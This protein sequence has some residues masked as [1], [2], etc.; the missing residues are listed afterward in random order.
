MAIAVQ[1]TPAAAGVRV[2]R[3]I[4]E[5]ETVREAWGAFAWPRVDADLDFLA[6][7]VEASPEAVRPHVAALDDAGAMLVGRIEETRLESHVGYRAVLKPRVRMLTV[8][9]GGLGGG[10]GAA[11]LLVD[12]VVSMLRA[13]EADVAVLPSLRTDSA[14]YEAARTRPPALSRDRVVDV[15]THRRLELPGSFDEF[16]RSRSK[17]TREGIKR[18]TKKFER[19]LGDRL[20]F[21]LYDEPHE[22]DALFAAVEPVA[23]K[24]Y[25]RGLGVA[26]HDDERNRRLVGLGL[27]RGWFRVWVLS[28]DG[29]PVAFWPG[30]VYNRSFYSSTPGYDPALAE[31]RLGQYVLMRLIRD[32]CDDPDADLLDFGFGDSEYKRRFSTEE[33]QEAD[34]LVFAP[35]FKGA[36]VNAGR[37]AVGLGERALRRAVER[38]GLEERIKRAW[39]RRLAA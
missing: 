2:A 34:V 29:E 24:T 5:L 13:G 31:Y 20:S 32:L 12:E 3:T 23:A 11:G 27:E 26:L 1:T 35:S 37:T 16:L 14:L 39:R 7:L 22:I 17:S 36:R 28:L 30:W 4:P 10:D 33:W 9:H 21:R 8:A 38:A 6:A 25:Q 19:E 18:Y 15:R